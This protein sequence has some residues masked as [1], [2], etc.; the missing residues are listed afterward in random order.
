MDNDE[1]LDF[2]KH[3]CWMT[4]VNDEFHIRHGSH[5]PRTYL[6]D[7]EKRAFLEFIQDN[8]MVDMNSDD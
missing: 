4:K 3:F 2:L 8:M 6:I 7:Q 5:H 1:A